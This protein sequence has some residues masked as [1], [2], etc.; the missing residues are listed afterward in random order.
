MTITS[1]GW[2]HAQDTSGDGYT[3][4]D[5][6]NY[7]VT[8]AAGFET[9]LGLL[10]GESSA[11]KI[12]LAAGTYQLTKTAELK[13]NVSIAGTDSI[14][15]IIKGK[16][17]INGADEQNVSF[18]KVKIDCNDTTITLTNPKVTLTLDA[19]AVYGTHCVKFNDYT[20]TE[21]P[22]YIVNNS[23]LHARTHYALWARADGKYVWTIKNSLLE[24]WCA[25]YTSLGTPQITVTNSHLYGTNTHNEGTTPAYTNGHNGNGFATIVFENTQNGKVTLENTDVKSS[26]TSGATSIQNNVIFQLWETNKNTEK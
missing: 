15:S 21:A 3:K 13:G 22:T 18:N 2:L 9:V 19:V 17:Y 5:D 14:G 11:A 20:A 8:T 23:A 10:N 7:Q 12:T 16:F 1:V 25:L 26:W 4:T 24:G 6:G